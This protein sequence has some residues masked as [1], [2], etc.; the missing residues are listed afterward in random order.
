MRVRR[1]VS[2]RALLPIVAIALV[3]VT[4][5]LPAPYVIESPGPVTNT[6]GTTEIGGTE[7]PVIEIPGKRTYP[8]TG[9]LDLLTVSIVGSP[10][11]TPSWLTLATSWFDPAESVTPIDELYPPGVTRQQSDQEG[12]AEMTGSQQSAVAAALTHLGYPVTGTVTV[13]SVGA[14]TAAA[15]VVRTGDVVR[16]FAGHPVVDSCGLQDLV[17]AHGTTPTDITLER[18]GSTRTATVAPR[19]TDLGGGERRPLLGITT[20]STYRFPFTV[21]LRLTD[22]DG[23]SAGMMFALG[24]IDELT[25]G[26]LTGGVHVA[27]TGTI[28]ADGTVGPIGGIVQKLAGARRAGATV[29]LAPASDCDEVVGHIPDGLQ[30]FS[31]NRLSEALTVLETVAA[32]RSTAGLPTCPAQVGS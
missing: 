28:C 24:I 18:A 2:W 27:G 29:F 14:R 23:P 9:A 20:W 4:A 11:A 13:R 26:S 3:F 32:R 19:S 30:V 12:A 17:L 1:T 25:P 10:S 16:S 22:V 7:T 5:L 31:V 15:G 6:L 8:T 21:T